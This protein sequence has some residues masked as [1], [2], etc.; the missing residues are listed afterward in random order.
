MGK[1]ISP[2]KVVGESKRT[3]TTI[4]FKPSDKILII[5]N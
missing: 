5:L 3:G 4:R 1:P 2:I